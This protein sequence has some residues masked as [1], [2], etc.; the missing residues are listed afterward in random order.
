M[1]SRTHGGM[2]P[3]QQR[4]ADIVTT[5]VVERNGRKITVRRSRTYREKVSGFR[6]PDY[7]LPRYPNGH[8]HKRQTARHRT[9]NVDQVNA[10]AQRCIEAREERERLA[11]VRSGE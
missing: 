2:R 7:L 5:M 11:W 9:A 3:G 4:H 10:L 6:A 1:S 8:A